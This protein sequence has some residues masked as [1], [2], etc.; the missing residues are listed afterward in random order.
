MKTRVILARIIVWLIIL[1]MV[2]AIAIQIVY[3]QPAI[4][5]TPP[6]NI[7]VTDIGY[8]DSTTQN[9]FV[10]F[11]WGAPTFPGIAIDKSQTFYF[12][13]VERGSGIINED[14]IEFSLGEGARQFEPTSYGIELEHGTIYEFYGR[15]RYTYTDTQSVEYTFESGKS[16]RVKFLTGLELNAEQMPGTNDIR[17]VWDDVWDTDGRI[18][19]RILISDTTGFTQPPLIPDI[20]GRDVGTENSRVT[21]S[22]GRL[23]YIYTNA[24]P[25][26]EY[27]ISIIPLVNSDVAVTPEKE[28][29]VV[30][31]KTEILL[32][33]KYLGE[34]V[35]SEGT[36]LRWMLF[37]D[38]IVKGSIGKATF[39][40]VE[41]KLYR[42]DE[43]GKE[44]FFAVIENN[45]RIEVKLRAEDV[46]KYKYKIEADAYR[47]DGSYV[48]F[49]S[50]TQVSLK[51]QVPEYPESPEFVDDFQMDDS[52]QLVFDDLLTGNSATL[53]WL[54]PITGEGDIDA[55]V[56]YDV[57]L[58]DNVNDVD[59][60]YPP[61]LTKRIASNIVMGTENEV[62]DLETE[63]ILGYR[64]EINLLEPN[65]VYYV[66]M[67]AKKNFLTESEDGQYMQSIP[68]LS[69]PSVKVIITKPDEEADKPLAPPS[70]PFRLTSGDA[71]GHNSISLRMEKAWTEMYNEEL[72]KWLYVIR[73]DD[74]EGRLTNGFYK[75][76]NSYT[77]EE[78]LE[79]KDQIP[80]RDIIYN[81]GWQVRVHCVDY[82][83]ALD[84]VMGITGRDFISYSDLSKNYVLDL[85]QQVAP[86]IIPNFAPDEHSVFYFQA[87]GLEPNTTYLAWIT[88]LNTDGNVE[89]DPSDPIIVTTLPDYPPIVEYPTVPT[90]LRGIAS[91]SYVDIFWTS[92][93]DYSYNIRYSTIDSVEDAQNTLSISYDQFRVQPYIRI[94]PLDAD[95]VYYF[96]VQAISPEELGS[97][98]SEWSNTLIVRTERHSPP[99][100][101][102]GFGIKRTS[103]SITENSVFYEWIDDERV[104]Y[105]L[106]ISENADFSDSTEYRVD[107]SEYNVTNLR[108]NVRYYA[109]LYSYSNETSLRSEPSPVITIVTR[110]GRSEY[111][112]DVSVEDVPVGEMVEIEGVAVDGIWVARITGVNAHRFAEKIRM[113]G[114]QT[115]SVDLTNPPPNTKIIRIELDDIVVE[116]L[117]GVLESLVIRTPDLDV[118]I[119]PESFLQDTYFKTKQRF[120]DVKVRVDIRT[121]VSELKMEKNR[122]AIKPVSEIYVTIGQ[123]ESFY[124]IGNFGRPIRLS[125]PITDE[126]M[127]KA[128]VRFY[129][130]NIGNWLDIDSKYMSEEQKVL[131][132]PEKSGA[133]AI[134][135]INKV[136]SLSDNRIDAATRNIMTKYEMPSLLGKNLDYSKELTISEGMKCLFDIIP[137]EYGNTNVYEKAVRAGLLLPQLSKTGTEPLS[138]QVAIYAAVEALNKK[139]RVD[140][141]GFADLQ[142]YGHL[143][144]DVQEPYKNAVAFTIAN[145]IIDH[146]EEMHFK[147]AITLEEYLEILERILIYAGEI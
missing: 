107:G 43:A 50:T 58:C 29:P 108:S 40:R 105:I 74:L 13:K 26:R 137:Y 95:T 25:G 56:Y 49:Y 71:V 61:P 37:W 141:K 112:A 27:S 111:D 124:P 121:P 97:V 39:T 118:A 109:R 103:D 89:S 63:R 116:T 79:N 11:T 28:L 55:E 68:Y 44:T 130:F 91:D 127:K 20:I 19:Y 133:V 106:E 53:L 59:V 99:P 46:E 100:R 67:V 57:Y 77:Y 110:R 138:A 22:G 142:D 17:I 81:A 140:V 36:H 14:I 134:T 85:Q 123:D 18:D 33:A 3:A 34:S 60:E 48:P 76:G 42:Y 41:Y 54:A 23:E 83:K 80:E 51:T 135:E 69:K 86:F 136:Q 147:S 93:P 62:R 10:E 24:L 113:P 52:T 132:F 101:P 16:N 122:Q 6:Q 32:R 12:N 128:S 145:G 4:P 35:D 144:A 139:V 129:D 126:D 102:R 47:E 30:R 70:P 120:K 5:S 98:P 1:S 143:V 84:N 65:T 78:Y 15:T 125:M 72:G 45:D 146:G 92:R 2:T 114:S 73:Q 9:W 7:S 64:Y 94:E 96:W 119:L 131:A 90:D 75:P 115:Y 82:E 66:V 38:P 87:D 21:S 88:I 104:T 8:K 31:I 117:S